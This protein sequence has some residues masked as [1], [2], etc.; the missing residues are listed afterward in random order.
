VQQVPSGEVLYDQPLQPY[1][2]NQGYGR[3]NLINS[4]PLN[5]KNRMNMKIVNDKWINNGNRDTYQ[6]MIDKSNGCDM[7]LRVTLAWYGKSVLYH[8]LDG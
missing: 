4:V 1:D 6:L 7:P 5:G 8:M 2:N 3:I